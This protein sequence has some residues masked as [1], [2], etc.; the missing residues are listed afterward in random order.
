[1]FE[2][3]GYTKDMITGGIPMHDGSG[4]EPED[5]DMLNE[6]VYEPGDPDGVVAAEQRQH[7][8][9]RRPAPPSTPRA[10][11][12]PKRRWLIV[13]LVALLMA[14]ALGSSYWLGGH[15]AAKHKLV[16]K[17]QNS[18][19]AQTVSTANAN[20]ILNYASKNFSLSFSYPGDWLVN[21]TP[22]KLTV[23]SPAM[24]LKSAV[25][26]K[27]N[28][29]V[30]VT[31]QNQQSSIADFPSSGAIA[32]L[33]SDLL[34]YK[35]P[36]SDQVAQTY[37]SYLSYTEPSGLDALYLTG[38]T[39]YSQDQAVPESDVTQVDPLISVGFESCQVVTCATGSHDSVTLQASSWK[40]SPVSSQVVNL[41]ESIVIT[42]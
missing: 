24:K 35:Q 1:M 12:S 42:D 18:A 41:I 39:S 20:Q 9:E 14:G 28:A 10:E 5:L 32:A 22:S 13:S 29:H 15:E 30:V 38:N 34:N 17:P 6:H 19:L 16:D 3:G 37:L 21:D 40:S 7:W 8:Q 36:S 4:K 23:T 25:G 33:P 2:D 26:A 11:F 31:V 27:V